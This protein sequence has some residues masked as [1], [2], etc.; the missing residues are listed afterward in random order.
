M[1]FRSAKL[2]KRINTW[3]TTL[4]P[5]GML[6][7]VDLRLRPNGSSGL[8][9]SSIAA[10]DHYQKNEAWLWE[11][12]ALTRA[13]YVAGDTSVAERFAEIKREVLMLPRDQQKLREEVYAMRHKMLD[14]KLGSS[15]LDIKHA[16]G[17]II[18]VEFCVQYLVLAHS[19]Q[20]P[21]LADNVGNIALLQRAADAGLLDKDLAAQCRDAYRCY[22]RLQHRQRLNQQQAAA[23]SA[24]NE[25][26]PHFAAV[27][28]M[29]IGIFG[30]M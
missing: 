18:D 7:E 24:L 2:A 22:R 25:L 28:K 19:A 29:W 26:Q 6:Y 9:V 10:F 12:Q 17:G 21:Q 8:L 13:R 5:A 23:E 4:T 1:L 14:N 30:E 11:H 15:G 27:S 20:Y 16:R 3:L